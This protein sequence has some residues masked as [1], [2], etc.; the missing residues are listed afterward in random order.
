[1]FPVNYKLENIFHYFTASIFKPMIQILSLLKARVELF[2]GSHTVSA[3]FS[4]SSIIKGQ[5]LQLNMFVFPLHSTDEVSL[6]VYF[7]LFLSTCYFLLIVFGKYERYV[8]KGPDQFPTFREYARTSLE[9]FV[10]GPLYYAFFC[11]LLSYSLVT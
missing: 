10:I 6:I 11:A 1:M 7:I 4:R 3:L 8:G 5:S 9:V 2:D